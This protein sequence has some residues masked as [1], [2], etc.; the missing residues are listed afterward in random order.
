[1]D[2]EKFFKKCIKHKDFPK[3]DNLKH[4]I[5]KR[6]I[7]D[8]KKDKE[9]T[10]QEVNEIVKKYYD[11]FALIRRELVNFNFLGKDSYKGIYWLKGYEGGLENG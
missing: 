6:I 4:V 5:L 7:K 1:M 11:D 9:Y 2:E 8:F 10:E 3:D